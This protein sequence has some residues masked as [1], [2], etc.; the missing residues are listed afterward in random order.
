MTLEITPALKC[1]RDL[2]IKIICAVRIGAGQ[3][4][5]QLHEVLGKE[6]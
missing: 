4:I 3:K 2:D 6:V 5:H 1:C